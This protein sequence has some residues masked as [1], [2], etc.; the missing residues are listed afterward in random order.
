MGQ[1][2]EARKAPQGSLSGAGPLCSLDTRKHVTV[3]SGGQSS[4]F[5]LK[6]LCP[7][8]LLSLLVHNALSSLFGDIR[9]GPCL[10]QQEAM[11][12]VTVNQLFSPSPLPFP[13]PTGGRD[14]GRIRN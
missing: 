12:A 5:N 4:C 8:Q 6:E 10:L 9:E 3:W 13:P 11:D 2:E 1:K 14:E 7:V